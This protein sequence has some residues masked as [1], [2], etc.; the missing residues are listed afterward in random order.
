M[1]KNTILIVGLGQIGTSIG[2]GL[3]AHTDRLERIGHTRDIGKANHAKKIGA[4]DKSVVNLPSAVGKADIVVLALPMDQVGDILELICQDLKPGTV[5]LDTSPARAQGDVWAKQYFGKDRY[6]VGFT[7]ILNPRSLL[8]VLGG[9]EEASDLLFQ[10]GMF[11]ITSSSQASS[12]AL[13]LAADMATLLRA[14]P[15][16]ADALE[17][18]SY[19]S[20]V[21]L[22][23]QLMA[24]GASLVSSKSPGWGERRKV[25]GRPYAQ[26][27]QLLANTDNSAALAAAA[28]FNKEHV[29][30]TLDEVIT[31]LTE[32]RDDLE[33]GNQTAFEQR[34]ADAEEHRKTWWVERQRSDWLHERGADTDFTAVDFGGVTQLFTGNPR[35]R[36]PG[37]GKDQ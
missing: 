33:Q 30:R 9:I 27:T 32:M 36:K 13:K 6:Y 8:S 22:L 10:D 7:P 2:L 18:D 3:Q 12:E 21:H 23:P 26:L 29:V 31:E 19:F 16:F 15:L 25:A 35:A 34:L 37:R 11:A 1:A 14:T 28:Q 17:V 5:V 24:A 20:A 4:V